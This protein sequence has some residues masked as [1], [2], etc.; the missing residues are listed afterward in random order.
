MMNATTTTLTADTLESI[1]RGTM[2]Q[3][4]R[5]AALRRMAAAVASETYIVRTNAGTFAG[6]PAVDEWQEQQ[7]VRGGKW[8][9]GPKEEKAPGY[10]R[11]L[12]TT[13]NARRALLKRIDAAIAV[14][15][16]A[17]SQ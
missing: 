11:E 10:A 4:E 9:S 3:R 12:W 15:T 1:L 16:G 8:R 2:P 7:E 17:V 14:A 5:V 13:I 6:N